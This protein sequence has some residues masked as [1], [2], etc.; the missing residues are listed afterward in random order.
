[1]QS[2]QPIL[3]KIRKNPVPGGKITFSKQYHCASSGS[4]TICEHFMISADAQVVAVDPMAINLAYIKRSLEKNL[5]WDNERVRLVHS[6]V[7]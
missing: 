2:I 1:M 4:K 3:R 5:L 7:R 6:A